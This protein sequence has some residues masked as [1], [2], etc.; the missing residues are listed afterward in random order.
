[1]L[2]YQIKKYCY[3][4]PDCLSPA[5]HCIMVVPRESTCDSLL[6]EIYVGNQKILTS[7]M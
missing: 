1:M 7:P 5:F 4:V 3:K 6:G 2:S